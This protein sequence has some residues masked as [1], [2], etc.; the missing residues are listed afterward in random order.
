MVCRLASPCGR[1]LTIAAA[2]AMVVS[3]ERSN[4]AARFVIEFIT[5]AFI[6]T[7]AV[8]CHYSTNSSYN[9]AV[10]SVISQVDARETSV[11]CIR[12]RRVCVSIIG[13]KSGFSLTI[14]H[15]STHYGT[16][17]QFFAEGRAMP[18]RGPYGSKEVG[19]GLVIRS[20]IAVCQLKENPIILTQPEPNVWTNSWGK[21]IV[22]HPTKSVGVMPTPLV[23]YSAPMRGRL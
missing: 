3:F 21:Y 15:I 10:R 13:D 6:R 16:P 20:Y 1:G 17:Y 9:D 19:L 23:F 22:D 18:H 11:H 2:E 12:G 7:C 5:A 8:L 4:I 14:A